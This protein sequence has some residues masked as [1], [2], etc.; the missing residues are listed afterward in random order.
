MFNVRYSRFQKLSEEQIDYYPRIEEQKRN[1][2]VPPSLN[3]LIGPKSLMEDQDL[4]QISIG[5]ERKR[6]SLKQSPNGSP[7][8][9]PKGVSSRKLKIS[10]SEGTSMKSPMEIFKA[11]LF[12]HSENIIKGEEGVHKDWEFRE[13]IDGHMDIQ[14]KRKGLTDLYEEFGYL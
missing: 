2:L 3:P 11:K 5:G 8:P 4:D 13:N 6:I 14:P 1:N 9:S 7:K 10:T 12:N